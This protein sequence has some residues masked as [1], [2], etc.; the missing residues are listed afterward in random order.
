MSDSTQGASLLQ[1]SGRFSSGGIAEIA[2][3]SAAVLAALPVCK[4]KLD[5][6]FSDPKIKAQIAAKVAAQAPAVACP[7]I[8]A[9]EAARPS[10]FYRS[11]RTTISLP[12]GVVGGGNPAPGNPLD[13][14][15]LSAKNVDSITEKQVSRDWRYRLHD[16]ASELLQ[17]VPEGKRLRNCCRRYGRGRDADG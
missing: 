15:T 14:Y 7:E 5:S 2:S 3:T 17:D 9:G 16:A 11:I 6:P 8:A 1:L 12:A 13:S 4:P 10:Y